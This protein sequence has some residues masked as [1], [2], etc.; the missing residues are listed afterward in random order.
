[1]K[2]IDKILDFLFS[3]IGRNDSPKIE[4]QIIP[5]TNKY[6]FKLE[7]LDPTKKKIMSILNV[8]ETGTPEGDYSNVSIFRDAPGEKKQI[9][10]GRSQTTQT[11]HL[12][13]LVKRYVDADGRYSNQ[14]AQYRNSAGDLSLVGDKNFI[15]LL[16]LSGD[17]PVMRDLQDNLFD[18]KYWKPARSFFNTN[19][20]KLPLSMLVFFDSYIHSGKIHWFLRKRF[21]AKVPKDGG[22]EREW[23]RQYLLTRDRWLRHHSRKILRKTVYRTENMLA[24]IDKGDWG[25]SEPFYA[26]GVVVK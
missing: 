24:A 2:F 13:E 26:N 14:L 22:D 7:P 20:F 15:K 9:T 5:T 1:M 25:L 21:A 8:W 3:F 23:I 4:H 19:G 17:D 12:P 11:S 16:K 6:N 10:F 18:N